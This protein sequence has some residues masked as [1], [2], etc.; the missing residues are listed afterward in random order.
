MSARFSRPKA[1]CFMRDEGDHIKEV[2]AHF[3]LALYLA[4]C[5]EHGIVNALLRLDLP[6][7]ARIRT[8]DDPPRT[9]DEAYEIFDTYQAEQFEKTMGNLIKQLQTVAPLPDHVVTTIIN[10]KKR[11]DLLAHRFFRERA[12]EFVTFDGRDAML[13]ELMRD[14]RLFEEADAALS[15]HLEQQGSSIRKITN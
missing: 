11:R 15:A 13:E 10:S 12:A 4:Q 2:F 1:Y 6:S 9:R 14:Q 7:A 8:G 3:G 5:L